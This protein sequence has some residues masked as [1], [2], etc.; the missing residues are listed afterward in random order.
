MGNESAKPREI[1][2]FGNPDKT[3]LGFPDRIDLERYISY[4]VFENEHGRYR[5]TSSKNANV[6]VVCRDGLAFGHFDIREKVKPTDSDRAAYPRVQYVYLVERS[7]VYQHPVLLSELS[8]KLGQWG[9]RLTEQE[10]ETILQAAGERTEY[11]GGFR[12]P[13]STAAL[14]RILQ[15]VKLRLGQSEFR[16]SLLCAYSGRCAVTACDV[17]DALEAAH[18]I[19]HVNIN[20]ND[21]TNGLLL[22]ADIHTLFDRHLIGIDPTTLCVAVS[23]KLLGTAYGNLQSTPLNM[24]ERYELRPSPEALAKRWDQFKSKGA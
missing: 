15:E 16:A 13:Q 23:E 22:R 10:F 20:S 12:L 6:I 18:I 17:A 24:P 11:I 4:G 2:A 14:E 8:L 19:P 7:T 9:K 21:P 5:Y 1:W 3:E